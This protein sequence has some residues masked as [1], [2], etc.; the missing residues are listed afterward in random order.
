MNRPQ[1]SVERRQLNQRNF[2]V[3]GEAEAIEKRGDDKGTAEN[4]LRI[5]R[6]WLAQES[7][8]GRADVWL[9]WAMVCRLF[10]TAMQRRAAGDPRVWD[11][12]QLYARDVTAQFPPK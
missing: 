7:K 5:T 11:D 10:L 4:W 8:S 3:S 9:G 6:K 2:Y 1:T 12:L